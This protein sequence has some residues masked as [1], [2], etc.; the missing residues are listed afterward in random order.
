MYM[1]ISKIVL[2]IK[3]DV[4]FLFTVYILF[5]HDIIFS[6]FVLYSSFVYTY[7]FKKIWRNIYF[8]KYPGLVQV[9][10]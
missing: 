5:L 7:I 10:Y 3:K 2:K 8:K 6:S 4:A 1:H 9:R